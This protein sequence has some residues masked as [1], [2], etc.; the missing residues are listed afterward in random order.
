MRREHGDHPVDGLRRVQ[1]VQRGEHEVAGLR[2]VEADFHGLHVAQLTDQHDV[3]VFTEGGAEGLGE[4]HRVVADL[5]LAH[6]A[7]LV[8]VHELDR[9]LDR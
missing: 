7:L 2:R 3:G 9:V 5:A 1:G 6:H 4:V 8:L